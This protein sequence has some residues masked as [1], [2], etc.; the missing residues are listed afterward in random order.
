[1]GYVTRY[2]YRPPVSLTKIIDCNLTDDINDSSI[3]LKYFHKKPHEER[4]IT[5]SM[6]EFM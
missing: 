2:M 5:Y 1:M 3:T 4:I 6:F